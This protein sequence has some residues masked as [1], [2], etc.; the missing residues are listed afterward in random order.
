MGFGSE[1]FRIEAEESQMNVPN[2]GGEFGVLGTV[3]DG[4]HAEEAGER[5]ASVAWDG[6]LQEYSRDGWLAHIFRIEYLMLKLK[7]LPY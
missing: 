2:R 7:L 6:R 1:G 4:G 3:L 5:A